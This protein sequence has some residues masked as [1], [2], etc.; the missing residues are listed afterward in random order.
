MQKMVESLKK[1]NIYIYGIIYGVIYGIIY[2]AIFGI[3]FG[4]YIWYS[5]Y[6]YAIEFEI[7]CIEKM[8]NQIELSKSNYKII[9]SIPVIQ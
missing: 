4:I 3:I 8:F 2:D 7:Q 9:L 5:T 1:V 6:I